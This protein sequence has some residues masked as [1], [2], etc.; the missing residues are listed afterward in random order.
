MGLMME[1]GKQETVWNW[2]LSDKALGERRSAV[3]DM[4]S[5]TSER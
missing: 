4:L 5:D 1:I 3:C 2:G